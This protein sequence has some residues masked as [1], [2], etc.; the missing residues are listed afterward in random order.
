M[1]AVLAKDAAYNLCSV[2][3]ISVP[4][5]GGACRFITAANGASKALAF[6]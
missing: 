2:E 6:E 4:I 3:M 5:L 1:V